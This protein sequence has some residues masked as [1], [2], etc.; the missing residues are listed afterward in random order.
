MVGV[1]LLFL[2]LF[3]GLPLVLLT[4]AA[5]Y[6]VHRRRSRRPAGTDGAP[7]LAEMHL[8]KTA[9]KNLLLQPAL[10]FREAAESRPNLFC[11]F[12]LIA[13]GSLVLCVGYASLLFPVILYGDIPNLFLLVFGTYPL[14]VLSFWLGWLALSAF[15]F[16]VSAAFKGTG[17]FTVTFQN[18]GY[19]MAFFL[20]LSG[21]ILLAGSVINA[22][23]L[24]ITGGV[25]FG[26]YMAGQP[27][28]FLAAVCG[29][30]FCISLAWGAFLWGHGLASARKIPLSRAMVPAAAAVL[31]CLVLMYGMFLAPL[32]AALS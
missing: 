26:M 6:L 20:L 23:Y 10:F 2:L 32:A 18:A 22:V 19:G 17:P 28:L 25:N 15:L 13:L 4:I 14:F 16:A 12:V 1:G 7:A 31:A 9:I 5:G 8:G 24:A 29:I 3:L 21:L 30:G 11:P 27:Q